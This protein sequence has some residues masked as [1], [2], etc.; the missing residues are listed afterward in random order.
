MVRPRMRD[1]SFTRDRD[2]CHGAAMVRFENVGMRYGTGPEVLRDLSLYLPPGS[3]HFLTGASG[4]GKTTLLK[5][6]YLAERPSRGR[7]SLFGTDAA[8][9]DRAGQ[10]ALRRRIGIVFQDFRLLDELTATDNVALALRVAGVA[11]RQIRANVPELLAWVGLTDRGDAPAAILSGGERQRVAIARAIV[12][13]P[14]LLIADE[15]TG[16]VDDDVAMLLVRV[17]ERINRLG[18]TVLI[19]THDIAFARQFEHRH[20]HLDRGMLSVVGEPS[21]R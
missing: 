17:F 15:P 14:E 12:R 1:A 10:A 13:R 8:T 11:E 16:N 19:A 20:F 6:L 21:A 2:A 9:L 3:F 5:L 7:I 4:A 18:T